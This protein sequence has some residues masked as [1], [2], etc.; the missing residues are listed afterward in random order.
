[1]SPPGSR[2]D[3]Q[4]RIRRWHPLRPA[5][6]RSLA[7]LDHADQET[8]SRY[9]NRRLQ[10]LVRLAAARSPFYRAWFRDARLDPRSIRTVADLNQLPLLDRSHL[11]AGADQFLIY[12]GRLLWQAH[13]SGTSG[14]PITCYRTPGSSVFELSVLERQWSWFGLS[15]SPR[16]AI[17]RGGFAGDRNEAP[18]KLLPGA[19]QLLVWSFG[20][21]PETLPAIVDAIRDFRPDAIEGWPSAIT[22]LASL[23]HD[24]GLT[25]PVRAVITSSE[26][27]TTTQADL[28]RTVFRGPIVD[29]YGQTERVAMAGSC[30]AGGYHVFPDYGIVELLPVPG[31]HDRW[32]IV[33]TALHNWGFPLFRYRTGDQ[34]GP[35]GPGP[36]RCGRAFPALGRIDGRV[37]DCFTSG[38]GRPLP[39]PSIV[40]TDL[41]NVREAQIAQRGPGRFEVRVVPM[42]DF[43]LQTLTAQIR[44]NVDRY[45]GRGQVVAVRI[46][47]A[48][49]RTATGKLKNAVIDPDDV[50]PTSTS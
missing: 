49:P 45:F 22:V 14:A 17:L 8:I 41:V 19:H 12:P 3:L 35:V 43:D 23:L 38:D 6:M 33:G 28:M 5:T 9:Q 25:M 24:Q 40:T 15:R 4:H 16:R 7:L 37:S 42:A 47:D 36:C 34:V 32:E 50:V 48:I 11:V 13:S 46:V 10:F 31:I 1:M 39:M 20:L 2:L 27:T 30:E 26:V 21:T 18:T 29:H 44:E